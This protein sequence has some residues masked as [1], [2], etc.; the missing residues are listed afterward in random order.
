MDRASLWAHIRTHNHRVEVL[1]P[2]TSARKGSL[3]SAFNRYRTRHL[4]CSFHSHSLHA[5]GKPAEDPER[6][7]NSPFE[8]DDI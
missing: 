2:V 6:F 4:Y 5:D 3:L 8:R 7:G 1:L